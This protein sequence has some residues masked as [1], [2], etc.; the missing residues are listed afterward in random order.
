MNED[1]K[2]Y[3][4]IFT[5]GVTHWIT[6]WLKP[7]FSHIWL[8]THDEFNWIAIN[9]TRRYLQFEI[10]PLRI[11]D[12]PFMHYNI[13]AGGIVKITFK[14]RDDTLQFGTF[15]LLNCVTWSKY[16]LGLRI[17]CLTP[18]GL[19]R[20]LIRFKAGDL[21]KHHIDSIEVHHDWTCNAVEQRP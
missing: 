1:K 6:R 2:E 14:K 5:Q 7:D 19:Y 18:F 12:N 17:W 8:L 9:P 3:W 11:Q 21:A 13:Q 4:V 15:G 16:V 10:L 20:R